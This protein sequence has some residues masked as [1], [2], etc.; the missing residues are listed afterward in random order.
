MTRSHMPLVLGVGSGLSCECSFERSGYLQHAHS[1]GRHVADASA[2][3]AIVCM[4]TLFQI[5][6]T[7]ESGNVKW[8]TGLTTYVAFS[9]KGG[10]PLTWFLQASVTVLLSVHPERQRDGLAK[11][12]LFDLR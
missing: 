11:A 7:E 5:E 6:K 8:A 1:P 10:I 9:W 3:S 4:L 2:W 12:G